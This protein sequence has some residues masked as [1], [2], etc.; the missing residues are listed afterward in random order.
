ML[1]CIM[2]PRYDQGKRLPVP[3]KHLDEHVDATKVGAY[4][5]SKNGSFARYRNSRRGLERP[6]YLRSSW[7]VMRRSSKQPLRGYLA[8]DVMIHLRAGFS[9]TRQIVMS[10]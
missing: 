10:L 6:P 7:G 1:D 4:C 3:V 5:A 2:E 9:K 8:E